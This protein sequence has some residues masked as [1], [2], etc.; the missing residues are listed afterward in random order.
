MKKK[1]ISLKVS[2]LAILTGV[3]STASVISIAATTFSKNTTTNK[4]VDSTATTNLLS[5]QTS[6][7]ASK[8]STPTST[9]G[10]KAKITNYSVAR[11][12]NVE[13]E[14]TYLSS[15]YGESG[16]EYPGVNNDYSNANN[17]L[18]YDSGKWIDMSN[19]VMEETVLLAYNNATNSIWTT[20][21][22]ARYINSYLSKGKNY[23]HPAADGL[24]VNKIPASVKA[25]TKQFN[26]N[27]SVKGSVSLGLFAAPGEPFT[28]TFDKE[29]FETLSKQNFSGLEVIVNEN[30]FENY[31]ACSVPTKL[32][33][34]YPYTK[35]TFT[36]DPKKR[37]V[38]LESPFGGM[39]SLNVTGRTVDQYYDFQNNDRNWI[40][41]EVSG[42]LETLQYIQGET[43]ENGWKTQINK[44]KSGSIYASA[45]SLVGEFGSVIIP[46]TGPNE[47][48]GVNIN[49]MVYPEAV[50]KKWADLGFLGAYLSNRDSSSNTATR[51]SY[52]FSNDSYWGGGVTNV[53]NSSFYAPINSGGE[54]FLTGIGGF[55]STKSQELISGLG[56]DYKQ[57][58]VLFKGSESNKASQAMIPLLGILDDNTRGRN[59]V[60]AYGA[61]DS[62]QDAYQ[63]VK[64]IR[65]KQGNDQAS[66]YTLLL[67]TVGPENYINYVRWA[68]KNNLNTSANWTPMKEVQSMS[69]FFGINLYQAFVNSNAT[70]AGGWAK[71]YSSASKEDKAIIDSL[72]NQYPAM[73]F[74]ANMY[75]SGSYLLNNGS[76]WTYTGDYAPAYQISAG[77]D[78]TFDFGKFI[79]STS[80]SFNWSTL[81]V[82]AKSAQGVE[83]QV[84]KKD[85]RKVIYKS[86]SKFVPEDE[87]LVTIYPNFKNN[88]LKN[89]V[90]SYTWKIKVK[91]V[92]NSALVST[93]STTTSYNANDLLSKIKSNVTKNITLTNESYDIYTNK[94]NYFT[95]SK[96]TSVR[97]RFKFVAQNTGRYIFS[98]VYSDS[99]AM[100]V[101]N[102]LMYHDE[103][104]TSTYKNTTAANLNRGQ[105]LD[106]DI[107]VSSAS[108]A[109]KFDMAVDYTS[110][111]TPSL[112]TKTTPLNLWDNV[113]IQNIEAAKSLAGLSTLKEFTSNQKYVYKPRS[114]NYFDYGN[115]IYNIGATEYDY[116]VL[117]TN[118]YTLKPVTNV[119]QDNLKK[120]NSQSTNFEVWNKKYIE[121]DLDFDK[122]TKVS[123]LVFSHRIDNHIN[124][125]PEYI[126]VDAT[127]ESG[128]KINLYKGAYG[129][130]FNDKGKAWSGLNFSGNQKYTKLSFYITANDS[131]KSIVLRK[132]YVSSAKYYPATNWSVYSDFKF[133]NKK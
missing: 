40:K 7:V 51:V 72:Q 27:T 121:F 122:A 77:E 15:R 91:Q 80:K 53:G 46:A 52:N 76:S 48:G 73:D 85:S 56:L 26:V 65:N 108:G 111:I 63:T 105:A 100:Y 10:V 5:T 41:F 2:S 55:N 42:A 106:F 14:W 79:N 71:S 17:R 29:T 92:T 61:S 94:D 36:V 58:N 114:I 30:N 118:S 82:E 57:D 68:A 130:Q 59:T 116:S 62:F 101:N 120:L 67:Y 9:T 33:T 39:I 32:T 44:L 6:T 47:F 50:M 24:Y 21:S 16:F 86:G 97:Y 127:T 54:A 99:M 129:G 96:N 84:D 38:T 43:S 98:N 95:S 66:I 34:R 18:I 93:Y 64:K 23:K 109:G 4:A 88:K 28:L 19:D 90:P 74:V 1:K 45:V 102:K 125:R 87:F 49:D 83:L 37:S 78:Y 11:P 103:S 124:S 131:A 119:T 69:K 35:T 112:V 81:H 126:R 110:T 70:W 107:L 12:T 89:Y 3:I 128:Q 133:N 75:A 117:D 115:A 13:T 25:V 31:S 123:S 113:V 104:A 8:Q 60:G 20:Y 132:L 22:D